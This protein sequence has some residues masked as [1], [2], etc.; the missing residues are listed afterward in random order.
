[1]APT[2]ALLAAPRLPAARQHWLVAA[3]VV[4]ATAADVAFDPAHHH[5]PLCPFHSVTGWWCPLCGGLRAVNA[6]ARGHI[7]IAFAANALL[8]CATPL[9]VWAWA[10]WLRRSR[11][12][13]PRKRIPRGWI[14][15]SVVVAAAFTVLRNLPFATA[16]RPS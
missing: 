12:G 1:M 15:A 10:D 9:L 8:W 11:R 16:L 7:A 14:L 6:A 5:V 13:E 4:V 2:G 3:S